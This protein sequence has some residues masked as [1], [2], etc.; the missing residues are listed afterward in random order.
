ML[1]TAPHRRR[2]P[3]RRAFETV[4]S[5]V[6]E[7]SM[8]RVT[9][10]PKMLFTEVAMQ[11]SDCE[12]TKEKGGEIGWVDFASASNNSEHPLDDLLPKN[13]REALVPG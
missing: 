10:W 13:V 6:P 9:D 11:M 12:L 7:P 5:S 8:R 3:E 1:S 4:K 2:S